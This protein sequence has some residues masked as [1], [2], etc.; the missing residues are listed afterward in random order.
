MFYDTDKILLSDELREQMTKRT[1]KHSHNVPGQAERLLARRKTI[2]E[3]LSMPEPILPNL[4]TK[5]QSRFPSGVVLGHDQQVDALSASIR[6]AGNTL[7]FAGMVSRWGELHVQSAGKRKASKQKPSRGQKRSLSLGE[8]PPAK[9]GRV[10]KAMDSDED[11]ENDKAA[12]KGNLDPIA[13]TNT[14]SDDFLAPAASQ[15]Q[16]ESDADDEWEP[17]QACQVPV[18]QGQPFTQCASCHGLVHT[19][20]GGSAGSAS[21]PRKFVCPVCRKYAQ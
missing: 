19:A 7:Q 20:C 13:D 2:D 5:P 10:D 9:R 17:C 18:R 16:S 12:E 4:R 21:R 11:H 1:H 3:I 15:S 6:S 8:I 14:V